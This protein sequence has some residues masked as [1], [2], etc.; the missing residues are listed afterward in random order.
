MCLQVD[1]PLR[2]IEARTSAE[3]GIEPVKGVARALLP[4][5]AGRCMF[6]LQEASIHV[7]LLDEERVQRIPVNCLQDQPNS[8]AGDRR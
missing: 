4:D 2:V 8:E 3:N 7:R 6:L 5:V 1:N